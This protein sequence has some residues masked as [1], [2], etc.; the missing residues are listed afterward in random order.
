MAADNHGQRVEIIS[1]SLILWPVRVAGRLWGLF[2]GNRIG[3]NQANE[4]SSP[5]L[6]FDFVPPLAF[7]LFELA[8]L[9][10]GVKQAKMLLSYA[11]QA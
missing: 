5:Y 9:A 11:R 3:G 1:L 7:I 4:I 2:L 6:S 8:S 10:S